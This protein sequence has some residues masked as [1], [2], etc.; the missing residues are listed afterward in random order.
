MSHP[1]FISYARAT[2][3]QQAEALQREL[4]TRR[5]DAYLDTSDIEI[6]DQF[7]KAILEGL[8][9]AQ[10]VVVFADELYFQRWYCI[11]EFRIALA[12]FEA[13]LMRA[14]TTEDER[15]VEL[16]QFVIALPASGAQ[17]NEL[18]RLPPL[19]Q[20]TNWPRADE[21]DK[22]ATAIEEKLK[23]ATLKLSERLNRNG[24]P[25]AIRAILLEEAKLPPPANLAGMIVY[26]PSLPA[27]LGQAFV[28]R[29]NELWRVNFLLSTLRGKTSECAALTGSLESLG[30]IGKTRLALEYLHRFG[31]RYYP[32]GLFWINADCR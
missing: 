9:A 29:A 30:G 32:G 31:P 4:K 5:V 13:V 21:T 6:D 12:P 14:N 26:P 1:V 10:V 28:G 16:E 24:I 3:R 27:S 15:N 8:L 20:T 2:S 17:P 22:V 19:L 7:P 18:Y 25:L 23:Y 11:R